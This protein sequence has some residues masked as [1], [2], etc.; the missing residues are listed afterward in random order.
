VI[1]RQ[2]ADL[3]DGDPDVGQRACGHVQ[4]FVVGRPERRWKT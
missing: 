1:A 4:Q 2:R 3:E